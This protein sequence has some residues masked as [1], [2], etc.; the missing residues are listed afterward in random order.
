MTSHLS[1]LT[2]PFITIHDPANPI[3]SFKLVL[4]DY[5]QHHLLFYS[6]LLGRLIVPFVTYAKPDLNPLPS[7]Q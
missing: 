2:S 3:S 7:K 5:Q 1:E 4:T 6:P